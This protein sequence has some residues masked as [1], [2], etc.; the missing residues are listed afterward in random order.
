MNDTVP[1]QTAVSQSEPSSSGHSATARQQLLQAALFPLVLFGLLS[2]LVTVSALYELTL[3]LVLQRNAAQAQTMANDLSDQG[4]VLDGSVQFQLQNVLNEIKAEN[5]S[6]LILVDQHGNPVGSSA[7]DSLVALQDETLLSLAKQQQ[8]GSRQMQFVNSGDQAIVAYAP[9]LEGNLELI[10]IEPWNAILTPAFYYQLIL[11]GL[12]ILGILCSLYMLSLSIGRVIRPIRT[13]AENASQALPGSL[14]RP[15]AEDGPRE[16]RTL[17]R[18]FNRM[19]IRLAEQQLTLRQYAHQ[20]LLSQEEE[21]QRLSHELHDGTVQELVGL[22]QRVELCKSEL[23][24]DP[25]LARARLEELHELVERTLVDVRRIS[26]ALRPSIL[27][28]LGLS[29][30]VKVLCDDLEE[31]MPAVRCRYASKGE[32]RRL[33]PDVELATFRVVQEALA[34]IRKHAPQA[35]RVEVELSFGSD[36]IEAVVRNDGPILQAP[37]VRTLV[38]DGH[39]GLA[40]MYERARLFH[41]TLVVTPVASGGIEIRLYLPCPAEPA[42]GDAVS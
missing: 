24:R 12:F 25:N 22:A 41:G 32:E 23:D 15:M 30:A 38:H 42:T 10:F 17:I 2:S 39:L 36:S 3:R 21:R 29:V 4:A 26:N 37:D 7:A 13:L 19:V 14:F 18:A 1:E 11:T 8:T 16:V 31:F 35:T 20:A 34:N 33:P 40:G 9:L 28:D 6:Q 5:G 27:E